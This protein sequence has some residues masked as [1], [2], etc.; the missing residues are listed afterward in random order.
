MTVSALFTAGTVVLGLGGIICAALGALKRSFFLGWI[1]AVC[2]ALSLTG[3]LI[4]GAGGEEALLLLLLTLC[5]SR[6]GGREKRH[7]L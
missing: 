2:C 4:L 5:A 6:M 3:A 1:A 7:E